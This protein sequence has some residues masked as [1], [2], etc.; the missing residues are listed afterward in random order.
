MALNERESENPG[1]ELIVKS[2][3]A[4][5]VRLLPQAQSQQPCQ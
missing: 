3:R 1:F 5:G 2:M 4:L